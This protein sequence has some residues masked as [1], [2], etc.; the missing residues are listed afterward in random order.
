MLICLVVTFNFLAF[1]YVQVL[2]L[3]SCLKKRRERIRYME[4]R[5]VRLK[6]IPLEFEKSEDVTVANDD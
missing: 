6:P 4:D 2:N 5:V 1:L 3:S